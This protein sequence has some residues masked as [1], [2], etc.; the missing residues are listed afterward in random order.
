MLLC[1][2]INMLVWLEPFRRK[3]RGR[4]REEPEPILQGLGS[5]PTP[6]VRG[7]AQSPLLSDVPFRKQGCSSSHASETVHLRGSGLCA[8]TRTSSS[9]IHWSWKAFKPLQN[10]P[11]AQPSSLLPWPQESSGEAAVPPPKPV[12]RPDCG[13]GQSWEGFGSAPAPAQV[14]VLMQLCCLEL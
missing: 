6:A 8:T 5:P 1:L 9:L 7:L 13:C 14:L 12:E 10:R 11:L 2:R 4:L 3:T